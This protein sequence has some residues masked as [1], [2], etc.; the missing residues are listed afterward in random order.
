M[1]GGVER[2]DDE[3]VRR[4]LAR[5]RQLAPDSDAPDIA[6]G[7]EPAA[8][9]AAAEDVGYDPA[10]V[11]DAIALERI[12][13]ADP[14][15][16]M[17]DRVS[18]PADVVVELTVDR[19]AG[20]A[21]DVAEAW[22]TEAHRMTCRRPEPGVLVARRRSDVA[23]TVGRSL[24]E[25]RGD[26][27][28]GRIA[29]VRVDVVAL[30]PGGDGAERS[31]LR[32]TADR[33]PTRRRRLTAGGAL[34]GTGVVIAA[35]GIAEAM[36]AWP[37]AAVTLIGGGAA[38]AGSGRRHADRVEADVESLAAALEAGDRPVGTLR[39]VARAARRSAGS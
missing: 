28:V 24:T 15:P 1:T 17:L 13:H 14:S 2:L 29:A 8:L 21:L 18:G 39:R 4:V 36:F 26:G 27:R 32:L 23:A 22:L 37:L 11:A 30:S 12:G 34:S 10:V 33:S 16:S 3:A 6:D 7:I 9:I 5:A 20:E 31:A 38:A 35:V 25:L 19:S